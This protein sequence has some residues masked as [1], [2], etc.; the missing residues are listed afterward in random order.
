[1]SKV[2]RTVA[3]TAVRRGEKLSE[4]PSLAAAGAGGAA[5]GAICR[6]AGAT[7]MVVF[8]KTFRFGVWRAACGTFTQ[9]KP[10]TSLHLTAIF[11]K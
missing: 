6:S 3:V 1:M 4:K 11:C 8:V 9:P 10:E 2:R 5:S 7:L